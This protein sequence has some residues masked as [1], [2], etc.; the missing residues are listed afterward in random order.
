MD[1]GPTPNLKAVVL[2]GLP[3]YGK[4]TWA[5][6][7]LATNSGQIVSSDDYIEAKAA[8]QGKTYNEIFDQTIE[9]ATKHVD[10]RLKDLVMSGEQMII[11]DRTNLKK[12]KRQELCR[13]L[14]F[15][16]YKVYAIVFPKPDDKELR[17]RLDAR[18]GKII[19]EEVMSEMLTSFE[20]PTK[21]EGFN[22]V[23]IL[24]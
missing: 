18:P 19:P 24:S 1:V 13:D 3:G 20:V 7:Y 22:D 15:H 5:R 10:K 16:N 21:D 8:E 2:V 23:I 17:R 12:E 14:R 6:N 4:T 11:I 9:E